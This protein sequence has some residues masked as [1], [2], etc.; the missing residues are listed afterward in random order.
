MTKTRK[1]NRIAQLL[2]TLAALCD[3]LD[4]LAK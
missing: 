1:L 2:R 3:L 4:K